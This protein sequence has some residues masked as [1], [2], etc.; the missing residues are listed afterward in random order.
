MKEDYDGAEPTASSV[1]A[2]NL[3]AL[4]HLSGDETYGARAQAVFSAYGERLSAYGRTLPMMAAALSMSL[5]PPEQIVVVGEESSAWS[6][7]WRA[8]NRRFRPF[9]QMIRIEP[10]ERQQELARL[11][12]W[13]GA[14]TPQNGRPAAY[15]CRNFACELPTTEAER[16]HD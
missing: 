6:A 3:L 14:M 2:W 8:A 11:L 15:V 9:T 1:G 7:L 12:P 13:L 4:A 10:G 5:V 16:L